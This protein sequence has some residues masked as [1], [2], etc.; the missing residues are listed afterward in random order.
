MPLTPKE[1]EKG[2]DIGDAKAVAQAAGQPDNLFDDDSTKPESN[3]FQ[4]EKVGDYIQGVLVMEPFQ[5]ESKFG[6][7]MVYVIQKADQTEFNVGIKLTNKFVIQQLKGASVGDEVAIRFE[8]EVDTGKVNP[9]KSLA[10][11]IRK[12]SSKV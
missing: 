6:P 12:F 5:S 4:F 8:K 3:W 1:E 9:A 2:V 11:R 10:V 7:Q